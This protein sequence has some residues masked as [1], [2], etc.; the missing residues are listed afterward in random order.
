MKSKVE[1]LMKN[2]IEESIIVDNPVK[3]QELAFPLRTAGELKDG[4]YKEHYKVNTLVDA[5]Q[6][7]A[8]DKLFPTRPPTGVNDKSKAK[9][10]ITFADF[11]P[12]KV[13]PD[14]KS[15]NLFNSML[16][17]YVECEDCDSL[18]LREKLVFADE[19][20]PTE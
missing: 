2:K 8:V 15:P 6:S 5:E 16:Q 10:P 13:C 17:E 12:M 14:C 19:T 3:S 1:E 7:S 20:S 18:V 11:D 9:D 4:G